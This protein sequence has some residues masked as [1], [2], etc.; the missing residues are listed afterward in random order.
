M[1]QA[2]LIGAENLF[3][4][5]K[6]GDPPK[7]SVKSEVLSFG[8]MKNSSSED[9][10]KFEELLYREDSIPSTKPGGEEV[11]STTTSVSEVVGQLDSYSRGENRLNI[12][13]FV[14]PTGRNV[15]SLVITQAEPSVSQVA[16][17]GATEEV[18]DGEKDDAFVLENV[19]ALLNDLIGPLGPLK[20]IPKIDLDLSTSKADVP[21]EKQTTQAEATETTEPRPQVSSPFKAAEG[22]YA[23]S[24]VAENPEVPVQSQ[25]GNSKV[26]GT[27]SMQPEGSAKRPDVA[28]LAGPETQSTQI[29]AF[30]TTQLKEA[31]SDA[32]RTLADG[33]VS[34]ETVTPHTVGPETMEPRT[35]VSS[36]F[37][38]AE[39]GYAS[40]VVAENPEISVQSQ[41]GNSKVDGTVS[42]QPEGS[43][44]PT[45]SPLGSVKTEVVSMEQP[46][47]WTSNDAGFETATPKRLDVAPSSGPET[48]STQIVKAA[49]GGYASSVVAEN[50][51]ISVQSQR[52][53]SKVDGT[54]SMQP[55][56][57]T[58]P[59][60]S[61][62]GSVKTEV[63]SMEQ[64]GTWTSSE[65][66]FETATPKRLD[67]APS[68]GPETQS[69]QIVKAAGDG[70]VSP[71]LA[72]KP[73]APVQ[74]Q[75]GNS[76]F[77]GTVSRNTEGS[78]VPT[79]SPLGSVKAEV[80]SMEQPG[81][82]TSSDAGFE[83]ATPKRSDVA[84]PA[85]PET[86]ATQTV[87]SEIAKPEK[88][89][90]GTVRTWVD[91]DVAARTAEPVQRFQEAAS[92]PKS[93]YGPSDTSKDVV[94]ID[95]ESQKPKPEKTAGPNALFASSWSP[96]DSDRKDQISYVKKDEENSL[97]TVQDEA[98]IAEKNSEGIS[99]STDK[100]EKEP[101]AQNDMR[102]YG[103]EDTGKDQG[104]DPSSRSAGELNG[105][106]TS[107][108]AVTN[109]QT[110]TRS[111]PLPGRG[112]EIL[113][114]GLAQV[115]RQVASDGTQ[116][117]S[118]VVDP[119]ALGRIEV[120][121][122][123]TPS[124]MEASFK[125]DSVQVRE[126]IKPQIPLLQ[127]ML[128]Q[129]G[130]SA[131][132]VNVDVRQGDDRRSPWR[133][134]IQSVK[135]RRGRT[136]DDDEVSEDSIVTVARIDLERGMLQWYA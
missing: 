18:L 29:V 127:D 32:V 71:V 133:D 24:V 102:S 92:K 26:E 116:R 7:S 82:W 77:E 124:G 1:N 47:T 104:V 60:G 85:G 117:A 110:A 103:K 12:P 91:G 111:I 119:P 78:T 43:T 107:R 4:S 86:Q 30:E 68:S 31:T 88:N 2:M 101:I 33:K 17:D 76:K 39:G 100:N 10:G 73:E 75:R 38:A 105:P 8:V 112:P 97:P 46:G 40:S 108:T 28:T 5:S 49:E 129:Q 115:V 94:T 70:H 20:S 63:V 83:T 130:I 16:S 27:V 25:R 134:S 35:Q 13:S 67:V 90:S 52:G 58:V 106:G 126:M 87:A 51:E 99:K 41:R 72:E 80:V 22:G 123:V 79:G 121:V 120:E 34:S 37:K 59:T 14:D 42:M 6:R 65:A 118:I 23:S 62:L 96:E 19:D 122:H 21:S 93:T 89:T 132:S 135:G 113:P 136:E 95:T 98:E 109:A 11:G 53:N 66:G 114:Q 69:T 55:E 50:P 3:Q 84:P 64:P 36:F 61:P 131:S 54:V 81:A 56:G 44:V 74:S 128:A 9:T 45:G 15:G 125:V 57:S 48:Q